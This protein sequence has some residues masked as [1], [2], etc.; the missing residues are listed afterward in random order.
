MSNMKNDYNNL[1]SFWNQTFEISDD[2]KEK[3]LKEINPDEDYKQMAPSK[4]QYDAL[5][6]FK[7]N[8]NVLDYGCGSGWAS[9]IMAKCGTFHIDAVDVAKNSIEMMNCYLKAFNVEDKVQGIHIDSTWLESQKENTYDGFFSSNVI[10][11][12]PLDMAKDIIRN[13]ARVLK[14]NATV[15]FSLNYYIDPMV[16]KERGCVVSGPHIYIN[17]VL[18]LTAL[19]DEEWMSLFKEY[20]KDIKLSYFAWAGEDKER[21]R[22]FVMKKN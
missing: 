10:D 4:K 8:I 15:I 2:D 20:F 16:M 17:D 21:R 5:E 11:V 6:I 1:V 18:R 3:I 12:I 14:K 19:T 13:A 22:L 7:D 9:I